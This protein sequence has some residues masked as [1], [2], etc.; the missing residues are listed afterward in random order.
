MEN[1]IIGRHDAKETTLLAWNTCRVVARFQRFYRLA[2]TMKNTFQI[3]H[4][5]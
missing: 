2:A 1:L 3:A 5:Q 4:L